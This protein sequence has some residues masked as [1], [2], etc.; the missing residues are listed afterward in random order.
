MMDL[1]IDI[2]IYETNMDLLQRL[3]YNDDVMS[4]IVHLIQYLKKI[5]FLCHNLSYYTKNITRH[6]VNFLVIWDL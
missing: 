4:R 2:D 6:H 3:E 5:A 1:R